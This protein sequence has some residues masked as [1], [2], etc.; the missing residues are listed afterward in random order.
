MRKIVAAQN[1]QNEENRGLAYYGDG[2]FGAFEG[3]R[4]DEDDAPVASISLR[5]NS[6]CPDGAEAP[7]R[8]HHMVM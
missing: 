8:A 2:R 5:Y 6:I 7:R 4:D 3:D 1:C